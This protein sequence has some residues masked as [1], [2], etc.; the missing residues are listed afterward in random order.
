MKIKS[1]IFF[2]ILIVDTI[3]LSVDVYITYLTNNNLQ[4]ENVFYK[5]IT[6]NIV[7]AVIFGIFIIRSYIFIISIIWYILNLRY[8]IKEFKATKKIKPLIITII[9]IIINIIL[10][11]IMINDFLDEIGHR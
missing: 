9:I 10:S 7:T 11:Q 1:R 4:Y 2:I 5:I 8:K 3:I 6:S